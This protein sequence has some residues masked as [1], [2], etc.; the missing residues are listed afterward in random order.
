MA[1]FEVGK[2]VICIK[3]HSTGAVN[4]GEVYELLGIKKGCCSGSSINLNIGKVNDGIFIRCPRCSHRY[5][6]DVIWF[7]SILFAPYDDS[8]SETSIED[9]IYNLEEQAV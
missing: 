4:R 6:S 8:L 2:K 9:L 1:H 5:M 3:D 7:N